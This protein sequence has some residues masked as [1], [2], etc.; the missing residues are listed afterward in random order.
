[1]P[2]E[3]TRQTW[4]SS[5]WGATPPPAIAAA[6]LEALSRRREGE[7]PVLLILPAD[8]VIDDVAALGTALQ[9]AV[10]EAMA[11]RVVAFGV[12]PSH[13]ETGYGY[14]KSRP[15]VGGDEPGTAVRAIDRFVEKPNARDANAFIDAGDYLWNSGM[16]VVAASRYLDEL[17]APRPG[18]CVPPSRKPIAQQRAI[19]TS[20]ASR[21]RPSRARR[22]FPW[23]TP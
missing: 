8:H 13:P 10:P 22:P 15:P 20:C 1:M 12:V 6:A 17:G 4:C 3:W 16:F 11:G 2:S 21:R 18:P 7:A 9:A 14:I 23:I 5:R 19:S